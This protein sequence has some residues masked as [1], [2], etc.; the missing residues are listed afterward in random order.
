MQDDAPTR[1]CA[2]VIAALATATLCGPVSA[3]DIGTLLGLTGPNGIPLGQ[4]VMEGDRV[5]PSDLFLR[6]DVAATG[7]PVPHTTPYA[8]TRQTP[9]TGAHALLALVFSDAPVQCAEVVGTFP[10][11]TGYAAFM[12][13]ADADALSAYGASIARTGADPAQLTGNPL[14][15][16]H[17]AF[18][19]LPDNTRFPAAAVQ[20]EGEFPLF[21]FYDA[22]GGLAALAGLFGLDIRNGP[23]LPPC[24]APVS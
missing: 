11:D 7:I 22:D 5:A 2:R 15:P 10:L 20:F 17:A 24:G 4:W 16:D 8:L 6:P 19:T 21:A 23:D 12:T 13:A 9:E 1:A 14:G 3:Q 18:V